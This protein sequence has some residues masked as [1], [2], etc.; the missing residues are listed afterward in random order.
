M[1]M[2]KWRIGCGL[3]FGVA[4]LLCVGA[5]VWMMIP[6]RVEIPP[7]QY[8]PN[9]AYPEYRAL[10]EEIQQRVAR[11]A[12]LQRIQEAIERNRPISAADRAYYLRQMAPSLRRYEQLTR[13]PSVVT[14]ER[15]FRAVYPELAFTRQLAR[16][17]SYFMREELRQR[18]YRDAIQR[19]ER[20]T[21]LADQVRNGGALIHYLVGVAVHAIALNPLRE[22][23]PR[24]QDRAALEA[25]LQLAR[26]Y[27]QKR[28]PLWKCMEEE[29]YF[30]LNTYQQLITGR[31]RPEELAGSPPQSESEAIT[32]RLRGILDRFS[33]RTAIP[34]YRRVMTQII[35][36]LKQPFGRRPKRTEADI[37]KEVRHPLNKVL[38]P[39]FA[40]SFEREAGEVAVMRLVGCAAAIRLHKLRT[41]KYP[42]SLEALQLG[43]MIIDPFSGKPFVYKTDPRFGFLLYS[44]SCNGVDDGGAT[45]YQG[46][47]DVR[48][49]LSPVKVP[50]PDRFKGTPPQML[51]L[52]APIWLR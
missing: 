10:G 43:E 37:E 41:G 47:P 23:L 13:R 2:R 27:E 6:P 7:R 42:A 17:D 16:I 9:N 11:D 25:L 24:I 15:D 39:V 29:Y 50:I 44:V 35:E 46:F 31:I 26:T 45:T 33:A 1:H 12:R 5:G 34:E 52:V 22:E 51:P 14:S 4:L 21:R 38:L 3:L 40:N 18:R 8:P 20:M 49:D 30:G 48:G 19:A 36:D 32:R 28:V